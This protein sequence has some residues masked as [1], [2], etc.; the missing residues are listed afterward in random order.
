MEKLLIF[1]IFTFFLSCN[2]NDKKNEA[3]IPTQNFDWLLGNWERT[4]EKE[5][6][7]TFETWTKKNDSEYIGLGYTLKNNDT[8]WMENVL[9]INKNNHWTFEVTGKGE[10]KATIFKLSK[11]EKYSFSCE[12]PENEFPNII[13][14]NTKDDKLHAL[15]SGGEM[16]IPFEFERIKNK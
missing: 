9:L 16:N 13:Q 10:P 3:P 11:I 7:Q 14:Y 2:T 12:N 4:N 15:I 6:Q 5:G 8:I 1:V